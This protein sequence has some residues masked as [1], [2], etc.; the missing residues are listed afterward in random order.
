MRTTVA[1]DDDL[2]KKLKEI[3]HQREVSLRE[4]VNH[5]LRRGLSAPESKGPARRPYRVR[6]FRSALRAGV[7]P[8]RLNQLSDEI[9]VAH[10]QGR[11]A[12]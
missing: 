8:L 6:T 2:L 9:E 10:A 3:A 1:I 5:A 12:R 4:V 7:D 11:T